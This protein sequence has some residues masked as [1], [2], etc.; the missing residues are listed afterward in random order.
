MGPSISG[1]A[2]HDARRRRTVKSA[3]VAD[4]PVAVRANARIGVRVALVNICDHHLL[5]R[6]AR[7]RAESGREFSRWSRPLGEDAPSAIGFRLGRQDGVHD[8]L[9]V[10]AQQPDETLVQLAFGVDAK[11]AEEDLKR[12]AA[13]SGGREG[14]SA[15]PT[16][17][18]RLLKNRQPNR[19]RGR[20][21]STS[22]RP[23]QSGNTA[24]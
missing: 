6:Q 4:R 19:R 21:R 2:T 15:D 1:E 14:F 16:Q 5:E 8:R 11:V 9:L 20:C 7:R 22:F 13:P 18:D 10:V 12:D 3:S 23:S 17:I 24:S